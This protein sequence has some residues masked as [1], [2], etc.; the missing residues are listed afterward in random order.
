ME[1]TVI[2][3]LLADKLEDLGATHIGV[4]PFSLKPSQ[5]GGS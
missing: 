4:R 2:L 1:R 5:R 3:F